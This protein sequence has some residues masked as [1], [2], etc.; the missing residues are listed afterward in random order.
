[1]YFHERKLRGRFTRTC[2]LLIFLA[3]F[4]FL[5]PCL[6][7]KT[8]RY[9]VL[10]HINREV[11]VSRIEVGLQDTCMLYVFMYLNRMFMQFLLPLKLTMHQKAL[12][13]LHIHVF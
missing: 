9:E 3:R 1:M 4:G 10:V 5:K 7:L 12:Q 11:K 8:N 6:L 2:S 13:I